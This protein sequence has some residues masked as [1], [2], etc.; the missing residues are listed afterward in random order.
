MPQSNG[1]GIRT[2]ARDISGSGLAA[3]PVAVDLF[4]GCGGLTLGLKQ[5]GY[6]VAAAVELDGLACNTYRDNHPT[7]RLI[8]RDIREVTA[9]DVIAASGRV[10][11]LV[12]GCPP[13]Q[14]FSS[15]RTKNGHVSVK[16]AD[17]DLVLEFLRLVTDIKPSLVMMENVPALARDE[18]VERI[19]WHLRASGY[20]PRMEVLDAQHFG[21]PQRR[22]RM[23]LIGSIHSVPQFAD[24]ES[25]SLTV[26]DTIGDLSTPFASQDALH[27]YPVR[28]SPSV[29]ARIKQTPKDGGSRMQV[30]PKHALKCHLAF[31]GFKDVYGRMAWDL[32]APTIT[33]GCINPSK[34][35]FLHPQQDRAI[36]LREAAMLQGFPRT[37]RFDLSRGRYPAA[38]LIGNAFPPVFARKHAAS[39]LRD[40]VEHGRGN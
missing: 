4:S 33:G 22:R 35:R 38:Q 5:A 39:L 31:D 19:M 12:A 1:I 29:M 14:G 26:R 30:S 36:T 6:R 25:G 37:Y 27:N 8:Q 2:L 17:N 13:C 15:I 16:D 21:T 10:P 28:R 7:T 32:P 11:D 24:S 23:I 20:R 40:Y 3:K 18:R 9:A 34:G